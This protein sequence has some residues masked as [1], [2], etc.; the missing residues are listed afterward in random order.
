MLITEIKRHLD[1]RVEQFECEL[2]HRDASTMVI[3]F[4]AQPGS[5]FYGRMSRSE[6]YFWADRPYLMYKIYGKDGQLAGYRFDACRD[7]IFGP[8][9]VEFTDLYL[10]FRVTPDGTL[11]VEDEDELEAALALGLIDDT[12]YD[13]ARLAHDLLTSDL[14]IVLAEAIAL[15][16]QRSAD[17][18]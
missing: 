1:G 7:V 2:L 10:D 13:V 8:D 18:R 14:P 15:M 17:A 9:F 16:E 6:G 3:Q 5:P 11:T 12:D 4:V